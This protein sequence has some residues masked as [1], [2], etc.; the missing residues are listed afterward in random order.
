MCCLK[1]EQDNYEQ[2]RK[3]MPRVGREI[4]TPDGVG[5]YQCDQRAGRD[6][7]R[8]HCGGRFV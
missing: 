1:Y 7:A 6:G 8:A 4:I 2:T 3:R 5:A